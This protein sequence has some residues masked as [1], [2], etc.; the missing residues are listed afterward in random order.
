MEIVFAWTET[1]A[2]NDEK[3]KMVYCKV[4]ICYFFLRI[5]VMASFYSETSFYMCL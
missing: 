4:F 2:E 5:N 3:D 1:V